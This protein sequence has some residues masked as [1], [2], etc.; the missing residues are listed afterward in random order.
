MGP[1]T[2]DAIERRLRRPLRRT[3]TVWPTDGTSLRRYVAA[4][5]APLEHVRVVSTPP[6]LAGL[7]LLHVQHVGDPDDGAVTATRVV[8]AAVAR[9][10]VVVTAHS[11]LRRAG[12]WERDASALVGTTRADAEALRRR[13]P[14]KRVDWIP[15]GC[16]PPVIGAGQDAVAIVGD[17]PGV[18]ATA[19]RAGLRVVALAPGQ[20]PQPE[21]AREL[22]ERC[23]VVVFADAASCRL[24][25]AAALAS[26]VPVVAPPDPSLDDF[27]G[28]I[29]QAAD[30][31]AEAV[32]LVAE[33]RRELVAAAREYCHE[34]SWQRVA[35]RH[36]ALWTAL[37][38]T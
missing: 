19:H 15:Y 11:V 23:R 26:G 5:V 7:R 18:D 12:A 8:E 14:A 10:P 33:P 3:W 9:V 35:Q 34:H 1:R 32:R 6:A 37:E 28:A 24:D 36:V 20:R 16:P 25:L 17:V 29:C 4:L 31:G 27:D 38:V 30:P 21:L 22:A 2:L 13:W